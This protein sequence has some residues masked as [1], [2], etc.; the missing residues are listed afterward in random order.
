MEKERNKIIKEWCSGRE[1]LCLLLNGRFSDY[2]HHSHCGHCYHSG[3]NEDDGGMEVMPVRLMAM[4][5]EDDRWIAIVKVLG[6][7]GIQYES[8][9]SFIADKIEIIDFM[10]LHDISTWKFIKSA[11]ADI[12]SKSAGAITY[13]AGTGNLT[14]VEFLYEIGAELCELCNSPICIAAGNGHLD[15]VKWLYEHGV[16]VNDDGDC[17]PFINAAYGGYIDVM[18]FLNESAVPLQQC[19]D[20]ALCMA[21][22]CGH[23][24]AMKWLFEHGADTVSNNCD[25]IMKAAGGGHLDAVKYLYD[26]G[27]DITIR[28]NL[29]VR[30]A[31]S[32]GH[33]DIVKWLYEHGADITAHGNDAIQLAAGEG[34]LETVMYLHEHGADIRAA[35]ILDG[36]KDCAI[37]LAS[38]NGHLEV[39]KYLYEN[40][41]DAIS[42]GCE[43]LKRA[44]MNG[45]TTILEWLYENGADFS[46]KFKEL[47][48]VVA[49]RHHDETVLWL[50]DI[51]HHH[52]AEETP[53]PL[54]RQVI[55][56][57]KDLNMSPGKLSAQVSHASMAFMMPQIKANA[58]KYGDSYKSE[59][60]FDRDTY[61]GWING[62]FTKTVCKAKNRTQL[63]KAVSIAEGLG[64][65]EGKDFFLIKDA[66]LTEIKPEETDENGCG[67]TLTCIGF[68]PLDDETAH[69]ISRKFQ[70]YD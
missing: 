62:I 20:E 56:A 3:V 67:R 61:E 45:H 5:D 37:I 23:V 58:V 69:T 40:G 28:E 32:E 12:T 52:R 8:D 39:V 70:L 27:I 10:D 25:V 29:V 42:C 41:A 31:A 46:L 7:A 51:Q 60:S 63:L 65:K 1:D 49:E 19:K 54:M 43:A 9:C 66:C 48:R 15:I 47:E 2:R 35:D 22:S 50:S 59:I 34:H 13:A 33:L 21:A 57:R 11:G 64:L 4:P 30:T 36:M 53:P 18:E 16:D 44:A 55:I 38:E 68:R 24:Q 26:R 14:L 6:D 17:I